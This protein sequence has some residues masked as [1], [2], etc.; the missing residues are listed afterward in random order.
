VPS[1]DYPPSKAGYAQVTRCAR[2]LC[3]TA[4]ARHNTLGGVYRECVLCAKEPP[5][6]V[7]QACTDTPDKASKF[8]GWVTVKRCTYEGKNYQDVFPCYTP[9]G[10]CPSA[11]Y[12][13]KKK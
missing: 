1:L 4:H 9:G 6:S 8:T 5:C 2:R 10:T 3:V 11:T 13:S 7:G 12:K